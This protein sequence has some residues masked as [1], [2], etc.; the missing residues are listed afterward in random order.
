MAGDS[1]LRELVRAVTLGTY[2]RRRFLPA[3]VDA[4]AAATNT[5]TTW[6]TMSDGISIEPMSARQHEDDKLSFPQP[7]IEGTSSLMGAHG[8][9]EPPWRS[10]S[11]ENRAFQP[12]ANFSGPRLITSDI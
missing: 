10:S 9:P 3:Q 6:T 7:H 2:H 1:E 11:K 8:S 4:L 12:M 5:G